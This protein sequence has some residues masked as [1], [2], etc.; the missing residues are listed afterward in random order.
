M[1][2]K[3]K[4]SLIIVFL[5]LITFIALPHILFKSPEIEADINKYNEILD[6]LRNT[7]DVN[8]ALLIFPEYNYYITDLKYE[9]KD[10]F[11]DGSYYLFVV[12]EYDTVEWINELTRIKNISV[13]YSDTSKGLL[14]AE[15][16]YNTY[17]AI[18]D[19]YGTY[20]YILVDEENHK[21]VYV[22][23]QSFGWNVIDIKP[24][25]KLSNYSVP[26]ASRDPKNKGYNMYYKVSPNG[27]AI[28]F[29]KEN[30]DID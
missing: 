14:Y 27:K 2:T 25:Y 17:I 29:D 11:F 28:R 15:L 10:G 3:M 1:N 22:F 20:E 6:K 24:E 7:E 26:Q 8:S 4:I 5:I 13:E 23:N 19:G 21:M 18:Y 9:S 30:K 16:R 12:A